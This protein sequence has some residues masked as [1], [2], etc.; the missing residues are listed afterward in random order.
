M[1]MQFLTLSFLIDAVRPCS[2]AI[3]VDSDSNADDLLGQ[4]RTAN[5]PASENSQI[6]NPRSEFTITAWSIRSGKP[7]LSTRQHIVSDVVR[8]AS[9]PSR[10]RSDLLPRGYLHICLST[11]PSRIKVLLDLDCVCLSKLDAKRREIS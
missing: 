11:H 5:L 8:P 2:T 6:E 4:K 1:R 9:Q 3:K 7:G 10:P